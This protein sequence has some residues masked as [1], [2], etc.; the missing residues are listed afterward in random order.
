MK[1]AL[2]LLIGSVLAC[3]EDPPPEAAGPLRVRTVAPSLGPLADTVP[4]SAVLEAERWQALYFQ[5]GGVVASVGVE[6]GAPVRAG[7][8]LA[9]LDTAIQRNRVAQSELDL[10]AA[11]REHRRAEHDL[12]RARAMAAAEAASPE[13]LYDA[14]QRVIEAESRVKQARL[15]LEADR[16]QLSQRV[17]LAPFDGVL[18]EANLRVGDRVQGDA[19][20]PDSANGRRPP[21][22]VVDPSSFSIRAS[23]PE[24]QARGLEVGLPA[25]IRGLVPG[26]P[27]LGGLVTWVAPSVDRSARTVAFRVTAER[28]EVRPPW[29]RDGSSVTVSLLTRRRQD[30]LTVP[31]QALL[32]HRDEAF[33]YVVEAGTA[34][35][36]AVKQGALAGERVEVTSGLSPGD[37]VAV[38]QL[39]LLADGLPVVDV[40]EGTP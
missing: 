4:V 22:V 15:R 28:T 9:A 29:L 38:D 23:L 17:L 25:E 36:A 2:F 1:P 10:E 33:V 34:R 40:Q 32:Y 8:T 18:A 27:P 16:I 31:D 13:A 39:H 19:D 26:D 3:G 30:A 6:E 14:E 21:L 24:G 5:Q 11:L 35:R 20:D 7:Q 37:R 12:D